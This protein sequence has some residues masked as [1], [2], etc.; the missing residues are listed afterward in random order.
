MTPWLSVIMPIHGGARYLAAT[1]ASAAAEKPAGVEFH[2]YNSLED[3]GAARAIVDSFA[4]RLDIVWQDVPQMPA[5][6]AKT[7]LGVREARGPHIAMLHQDDLWLPGH[8]AAVRQALGEA[9]DVALQIGP[10]RFIGPNDEDLGPWRLPFR[11]PDANSEAAVRTLLVQNTIAVN[12]PII[13]VDAWQAVGGLYEALW[14]TADW[15]L[16][17]KLAKLGRVAVRPRATTAFRVHA[18]SLTMTGSRDAVAFRAQHDA[19]LA[20]HLSPETDPRLAA[21]ARA[22]VAVNCSLAEAASGNRRALFAGV[23][24]I[25]GLGPLGAWRYVR[26]A[27]LWDRARPRLAL[28]PGA[29]QLAELARYSGGGALA[30]VANNIVLIAGDRVGLPYPALLALTW[31]IGGSIGYAWHTGITFAAPRSLGGYARFLGGMALGVA[32][33]GGLLWGLGKGLGWPMMVVAPVVTLSMFGFN[34]GAARLAIVRRR[35]PSG[36]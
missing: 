21:R 28:R 19:V 2:L 8:L 13:R 30:V 35:P 10:S 26:K 24:A 18:Q 12:A 1:L 14:Y 22:S 31:L 11:A 25:L 5:W 29:A 17:L 4:D 9:P 33:S 32:L 16:Y 3:G 7:N 6:T 20:R 23:M 34:Y 27:A 15:D 36:Q